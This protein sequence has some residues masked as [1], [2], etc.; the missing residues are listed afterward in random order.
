MEDF[1]QKIGQILS[2]PNALTSIMSMAKGLGFLPEHES[3]PARTS[4]EERAPAVAPLTT[5]AREKIENQS[6]PAAS[7]PLSLL[8]IMGEA[9]KM[10]GKHAA[11]FNALKPFIKPERRAKIEKAVRA[12][13]IS[14]VAGHAIRN[15]E[16][17]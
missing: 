4:E 14:Q 8:E 6:L 17:K 7:P 13:Q 16:R 12:A 15:L 9:S 2:D 3:V 1:E 11:L 5:P 10:D